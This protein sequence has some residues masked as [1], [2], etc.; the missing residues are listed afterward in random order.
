MQSLPPLAIPIMI[1]LAVG[2]LLAFAVFMR[3]RRRFAGYRDLADDARELG[4]KL[5]GEVFRDGNDLVINGSTNG[6]PVQVRFSH[7]DNMPGLDIRLGAPAN[8]NLFVA[9]RSAH[10]SEGKQVVRTTDEMLNARVEARSDQPTQARL[11][12]T[13]GYVTASLSALCRSAN[14]FVRITRGTIELIDLAPPTDTTIRNVPA[15]LA[16]MQAIV[17]QIRQMPGADTVK[18]EPLKRDH[19]YVLKAA[20]AAGVVAVVAAVL[21]GIGMS[22]DTTEPDKRAAMPNAVLDSDAPLIPSLANWRVAGVNSF[23]PDEVSWLRSNGI[24]IEGRISA[25]FSGRGTPKDV[26]YVLGN[27]AGEKRVVVL[28]NGTRIFDTHYSYL[29]IAVRVPHQ[30]IS[31]IEWSGTPPD[32]PAGDGLLI[33]RAPSD[34]ASGLIIFTRGGQAISGVPKDYQSIRLE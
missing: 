16:A 30:F 26:A 6:L 2:V 25:D 27:P 29:G 3:D 13:T 32:N 10:A 24:Q 5:N 18:I 7:S 31:S 14:T 15:Q 20:L 28:S 21:I 17:A 22:A 11:L 9:P 33:V 19:R 4:N 34:R 23:S 1:A 8:F 12:L